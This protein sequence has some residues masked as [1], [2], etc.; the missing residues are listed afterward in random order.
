MSDLQPNLSLDGLDD[1]YFEDPRH[2][3]H[4]AISI[5]RQWS[6]KS[7]PLPPVPG[8]PAMA[9]ANSN[10]FPPL[11]NSANTPGRSPNSGPTSQTNGNG[12]SYAS[13]YIPPLPVGHQQDLTFLYNQIQELSSILQNNR[14]RVNDVTRSAEEVARR[15]NL[16]NGHGNE[17]ASADRESQAVA[18]QNKN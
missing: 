8:E 3:S 11:E 7:R 17:D 1:L 16:T 5:A 18:I 2:A 13:N 12:G 4:E 9:A 10:S 14:E 6:P 15:A